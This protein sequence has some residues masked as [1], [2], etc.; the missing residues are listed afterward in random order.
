MRLSLFA[1]PLLLVFATP[2]RAQSSLISAVDPPSGKVG[3]VLTAQGTNLGKD[4][5]AALY[6]TDGTTDVK[7]L[8]LEQTDVLLRFK[9]PSEAKPGRFALMVLTKSKEPKLIEEPVKI[10][11]EPDTSF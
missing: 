7:V 4:A 11:V 5:I 10:T 1:I 3:D 2:L 8:I 6:L 9:I